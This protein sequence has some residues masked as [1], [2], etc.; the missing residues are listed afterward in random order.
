M[1]SQKKGINLL[2]E[3]LYLSADHSKMSRLNH[4]ITP[5]ID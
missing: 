3:M 4:V 2:Y 5:I 1:T